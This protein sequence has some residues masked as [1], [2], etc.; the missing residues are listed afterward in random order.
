[1]GDIPEKFLLSRFLVFTV[2][3][4]L[5]SYA[6]VVEGGDTLSLGASIT[7]NQTIISENGTFELGFFSP[8][9]TTNWYIGIWYANITE[10]TIVWVAN[11][12]NPARN[13]SGV[14]KLSKEGD[15]E[16]FDAEG[17]SLWSADT[18][19]KASRAVILDS[20]N[21]VM[22]SDENKFETVWQSFDYPVGTLL[23]GMRFGGQQKLVSWKSSLDPAP[24]L[25]SYQSDPSG[26]KQ[27]V[28]IWNSSVQ[29]WGSGTWDGNAFSQ[30]PEMRNKVF[31][32]ISVENTN[33]ALYVTYTSMGIKNAL[34]RFVLVNSG[35][36]QLYGL[37]DD[38][39]WSL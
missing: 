9:G 26:V 37:L 6:A 2:F 39:K 36:T 16:L 11:R 30:I 31:Y 12:E 4:Q 1:M 13:R 20:G 23:P 8:N 33:S 25:F 10:K 22:L 21:L 3:S 5:S 7:G 29:Y 15:L 19:N 28:L 35:G 32:N 17:A 18:S 27:L 34:S 38:A 24:G 14:L